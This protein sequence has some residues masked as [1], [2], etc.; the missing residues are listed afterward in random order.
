MPRDASSCSTGALTPSARKDWDI[1]C[2]TPLLGLETRLETHEGGT[3]SLSHGTTLLPSV[4][5]TVAV[6]AD[7][8][9]FG[10]YAP[11]QERSRNGRMARHAMSIERR[12][13]NGFR[14]RT[15]GREAE[16][17]IAFIC[18]GA[19]ANCR[20]AVTFTRAAYDDLRRKGQPIL[21]PA[22]VPD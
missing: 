5:I 22:H 15:F 11:G 16:R 20:R 2:S 13:V 3:R 14:L 19:D 18:D 12:E 7:A 21:F 6:R 17:L 9:L 10:V 1:C 4:Q 8:V